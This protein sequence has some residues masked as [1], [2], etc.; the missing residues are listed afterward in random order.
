M[1]LC[2]CTVYACIYWNDRNVRRVEIYDVPYRGA[3]FNV[4]LS[5]SWD[6]SMCLPASVSVSFSMRA[7]FYVPLSLSHRRSLRVAVEL[8]YF[9]H[10]ILL[11]TALYWFALQHIVVLLFMVLLF[12]VYCI[13]SFT[14]YYLVLYDIGIRSKLLALN[15]AQQNR[16]H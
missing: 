10:P 15:R 4:G 14:Y 7:S 2:V 11:G 12:I 9:W 13:H 6:L 3:W 1:Y 8:L 5:L 16:A